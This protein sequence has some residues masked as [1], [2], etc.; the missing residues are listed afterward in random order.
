MIIIKMDTVFNNEKMD[1]N[2]KDNGKEIK[3][4]DKE[5]LS[6]LTEGIL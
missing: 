6:T 2:I 3:W 1:R 5:S 4:M